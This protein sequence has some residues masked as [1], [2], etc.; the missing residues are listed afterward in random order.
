MS[1]TTAF[2]PA[3]LPKTL[4]TTRPTSMTLTIGEKEGGFKNL[5]ALNHYFFFF[6]SS[7]FSSFF[8]FFMGVLCG[9]LFKDFFICL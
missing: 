2:L 4:T 3:S 7:L 9:C 6:F 1:T 8:S 5:S